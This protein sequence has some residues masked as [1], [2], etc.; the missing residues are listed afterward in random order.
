MRLRSV[1]LASACAVLV[2]VFASAQD[3]GVLNSAETIN[4]S[5]FKLDGAPMVTFGRDGSESTGGAVVSGGYGFTDRLDAEGRLAFFDDLTRVGGDV[6][7]W[8]V[9]QRQL[10]VS[11]S[12]G[13]HV[14]RVDR[15]DR[16]DL[17]NMYGFDVT[18]LTSG[19]V[20][21]RLELYGGL[22]LAFNTI[23]E[24]FDDNNYT[25]VH[26]VPG[27]EFSVSRDIDLVA[28]F[29]IGLNDDSRHYLAGGVAFYFR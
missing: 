6:E 16:P 18:F 10:D 11:L 22:D 7:Y 24:D 17:F 25:T 21:P 28:E 19:H 9:K 12:G 3:F 27:I 15:D 23:T 13:F 14:E 20:T 26:L 2:P 5:N 4:R 8:L 29:G 1:L